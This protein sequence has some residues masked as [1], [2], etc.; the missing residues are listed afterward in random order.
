MPVKEPGGDLELTRVLDDSQELVDFSLSKLTGAGRV[1]RA[2]VGY[3]KISP[4]TKEMIDGIGLV[5][6]AQINVGLL[7]DEGGKAATNT[8]DGSESEDDLLSAV[9]VCVEDT[10]DV[11]EF[12]GKDEGAL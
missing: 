5:P 2:P 4:E 6:L 8:T 7:A 9:H 3:S 12:T 10:E 11:L 1:R